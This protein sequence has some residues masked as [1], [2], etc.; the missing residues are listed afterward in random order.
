MEDIIQKD[1]AFLIYLNN[2]GSEQWDWL[3]LAITNQFNW[4]PLFAFLIFLIF[5]HLGWKKA[6]FT[7]VFIAVLITFSDQFTNLIRRTFERLRPNNDPAIQD[8]LRRL[9]NPQS[10]SFTS[11]HA[12]TSTV[13]TVFL[14]M[15]LRKYVPAIKY[16]AVFPLIFAYSRLYLGVH[17]PIDILCGFINGMIIGFVSA[18]LYQFLSNKIF[19]E[20]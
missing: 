7:L 20:L 16:L 3:W 14:I 8:S 19:K 5:K 6:A 15:L 4:I 2:L 12:T 9:I 13:V 11:G 10:Y 17:F 18:K 1:Q